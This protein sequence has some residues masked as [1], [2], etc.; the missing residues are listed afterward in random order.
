MGPNEYY[1]L[2]TVIELELATFPENERNIII[3]GKAQISQNGLILLP[4][5]GFAQKAINGE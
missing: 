1:S 5:T 4:G 3:H 2:N